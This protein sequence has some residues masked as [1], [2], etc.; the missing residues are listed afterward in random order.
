M[1]LLVIRHAIAEDQ[2]I[3]AKTGESD[4]QRP[5][6]DAGRK[7]MKRAAKGLK[8]EVDSIDLLA[9]SPLT[10]AVQTA[11]IVAR[12]FK[13]SPTTVATVLAPDQ[14][15][16][17]FLEW[18]RSIDRAELVAIVGHEPHLSKLVSWLVSGRDGSVIELKKGAACL[19]E[20]E[21]LPASGS[22][23]LLWALTPDQLRT[24][25]EK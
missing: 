2:E 11:E 13:G 6:T 23:R 17:S 21:G 9:T 4:D 8:Q 1:K 25:A 14:S 12:R 10:R 7:K 22:A 5:L 16:E 3:W 24:L 20:F 15:N 19:L 18:L